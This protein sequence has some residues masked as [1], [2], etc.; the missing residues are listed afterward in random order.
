MKALVLEEYNNLVVRDVPEPEPAADEVLIQIKA[1]GICGSDVHGMDGSTGRRQPPIIMGHEAAGVIERIGSDV[2]DW[3]VGDRV[4]FDST[5][6]NFDCW[7][8]RRGMVNLAENRKVLGV[9]CDDYRRDG[10]FAEYVAVPQHILYRLP[11][12]LS[13]VQAAMV[14]PLAVSAHAVNRT[15]LQLGDSVVVVGTGMIGL[16]LVQVLRA[17]GCGTIIAVDLD[18]GKLDLAKQFGADLTLK[19]DDR[20]IPAE[21]AKATEG[22]GADR[23]FEVVGAT[24]A[25]QTTIHSVRKGGSITLVGNL[26]PT[27]ELPLQAVV[28]REQALFGSCAICGEYGACLEMIARGTA[29]VDALISKVAPLDEGADWFK[30][31]Y[32]GEPGLMKVILE[33]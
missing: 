1:V 24:A 2:Q 13:F 21:V 4:T 26:S 33:P 28:T 23:G 6:Y 32:A 20:D 18:Q 12:A 3:A 19:A 5:I 30:R 9:S 15:P 27:V 16:L 11:G 14:E 25:V 29:N 10:A 8:S 17:A 31:L 22:R 7:F